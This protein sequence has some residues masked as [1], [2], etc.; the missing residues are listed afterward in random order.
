MGCWLRFNYENQAEGEF[1]IANEITVKILLCTRVIHWRYL[2]NTIY[3]ILFFFL[4]QLKEDTAFSLNG[5]MYMFFFDFFLDFF[6]YFSFTVEIRSFWN[7][8]WMI[9]QS[10]ILRS[11]STLLCLSQSIIHTFIVIVRNTK[12]STTQSSVRYEKKRRKKWIKKSSSEKNSHTWS[13]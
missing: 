8:A 9:I 11:N 1:R 3:V 4:N 2:L 7:K 13:M 12:P 5:T 6:F 10:Y